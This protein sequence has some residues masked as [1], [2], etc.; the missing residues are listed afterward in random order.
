MSKFLTNANGAKI[1]YNN[2]EKHALLDCPEI[3]NP[4]AVGKVYVVLSV[5]FLP[6]KRLPV[7]TI[8]EADGSAVAY[9]LPE[10]LGEWAEAVVHQAMLGLNPFPADV[11][12]GVLEGRVYAEI[13]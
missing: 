12:F 13:I 4:Q 1:Y 5:G 3:P 7:V 10:G 2:P 8:K 9:R 11:D 6:Q